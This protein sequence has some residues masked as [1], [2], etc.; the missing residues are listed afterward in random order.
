MRQYEYTQDYITHISSSHSSL[1]EMGWL[2]G[3]KMGEVYEWSSHKLGIRI[4][5]RS[6]LN[7]VRGNYF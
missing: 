7:E 5:C 2:D 6:H 1:N 4:I 3:W